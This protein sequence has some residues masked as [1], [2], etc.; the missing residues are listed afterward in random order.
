[1]NQD[2]VV[3]FLILLLFIVVPLAEIAIL[4]KVG[5]HIGWLW[6]ILIVV[7]TAFIG[8]W[9]LRQQ[10][11]GVMS[12]AMEALASGRM[13]V[14]PVIEGMC[15]LLAGAFLLTPGLLTDAVGFLLLVPV[16]RMAVAKWTLKKMLQSGSVHVSVFGEQS[17]NDPEAESGAQNE[18][19]RYGEGPIIDGEFE[20]V[21]EHS[22]RRGGKRKTK[23]R[24][25]S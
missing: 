25:G 15:L 6:T 16:I 19:H 18:A 13:P 11:F 7:F 21:D 4:I 1:L 17:A 5:Q 20:R 8:T 23:D 14:E 24:G 10:G 2:L 9:L 12:R 22:D 3:P